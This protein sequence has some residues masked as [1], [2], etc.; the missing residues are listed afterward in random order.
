[1][2]ARRRTESM[3]VLVVGGRFWESGLLKTWLKPPALKV[4]PTSVCVGLALHLATGPANSVRGWLALAC[5]A[6]QRYVPP[7]PVTS[8][9]LAGHSTVGK[10]M[11]GKILGGCFCELAVPPSPEEPNPVRP[12]ARAA[13]Q[14]CARS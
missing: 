4:P 11:V 13:I 1:M 14:S 12:S 10:G 5:G 3:A 2:S 8:G 7:T 9:S 6:V